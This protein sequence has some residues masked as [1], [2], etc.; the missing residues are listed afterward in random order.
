MFL[1]IYPN[2]YLKDKLEW[3]LCRYGVLFVFSIGNAYWKYYVKLPSC[4]LDFNKNR[5]KLVIYK[6]GKTSHLHH[7]FLSATFLKIIK[8]IKFNINTQEVRSSFCCSR[9]NSLESDFV[10]V[11][12]VPSLITEAAFLMSRV[13]TTSH[14]PVSIYRGYAAAHLVRFQECQ[15]LMLQAV[16]LLILCIWAAHGQCG[17]SKVSHVHTALSWRMS[18]FSGSWSNFTDN[19]FSFL[20]EWL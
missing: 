18:C 7:H 10:Y 1:K 19:S 9:G 6:H 17:S 13:I 11:P 14:G 16:I 12:N 5:S 2:V 3:L 20:C 4:Y 15:K 8:I